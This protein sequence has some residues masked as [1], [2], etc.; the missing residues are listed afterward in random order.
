MYVFDMYHFSIHEY[1]PQI[2]TLTALFSQLTQ[3]T[4][5][6]PTPHPYLLVDNTTDPEEDRIPRILAVICSIIQNHVNK[7]ETHETEKS[8]LG[9]LAKES[10]ALLEALCLITPSD[11][12]N[13]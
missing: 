5:T 8:E 1:L 10:L 4:Y 13:R 6:L 12:E 7:Q 3:I 9:V 2:T 11:L